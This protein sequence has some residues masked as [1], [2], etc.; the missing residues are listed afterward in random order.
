MTPCRLVGILRLNVD[1]R[2]IIVPDV[3]N[4]IVNYTVPQFKGH[5]LNLYWDEEIIIISCEVS[6]IPD[7]C[8]Y[9]ITV[10]CTVDKP[11]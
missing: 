6:P 2:H 9:I 11:A 5:S 8:D 3:K 1:L 7:P 4:N 10:H